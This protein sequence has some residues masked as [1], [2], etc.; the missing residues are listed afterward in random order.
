MKIINFCN[1]YN[2]LRTL[3]DVRIDHKCLINFGPSNKQ[4]TNPYI[5]I[6]ENKSKFDEY[7]YQSEQF[8]VLNQ[9]FSNSEKSKLKKTIMNNKYLFDHLAGYYSNCSIKGYHFIEQFLIDK[10]HNLISDEELL[11]YDSNLIKISFTKTVDG[12]KYKKLNGSFLLNVDF[13]GYQCLALFSHVKSLNL[14]KTIYGQIICP[15][16]NSN[17]I[18]T[19]YLK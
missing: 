18:K 8:Y 17:K 1:A 7:L 15:T 2:A 11:Y 3:S 4:I 6:L 12:I 9:M 13:V 16:F 5:D 14:V 19:F 10:Q